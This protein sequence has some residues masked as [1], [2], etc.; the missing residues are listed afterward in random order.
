MVFIK[1]EESF[2][3]SSNAWV[4]FVEEEAQR[5]KDYS[6]LPPIIILG[7]YFFLKPPFLVFEG[8]T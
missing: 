7:P 6:F 3:K 8:F 1:I 2:L 5:S 4:V